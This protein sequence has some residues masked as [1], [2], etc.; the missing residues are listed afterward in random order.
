MAVVRESPDPATK[1]AR[2]RQAIDTS[3][4]WR[5]PLADPPASFRLACLTVASIAIIVGGL[6]A[7]LAMLPGGE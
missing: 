4:I 6:M 7:T 3:N 1:E 5:G 2:L